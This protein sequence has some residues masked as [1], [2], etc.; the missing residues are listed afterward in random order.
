MRRLWRTASSD[1]CRRA[2]E[3]G[4]ALAEFALIAP[5]L[6]MFLFGIIEF[7]FVLSRSQAVEAAAR[8]GGRLASLS[9][10]DFSTIED[11][12]DTTLTGV[13]LDGPPSVSV[14]P[15]VCDGREGQSV[16][17]TV[18][19]PHRLTIPFVFDRLM[20]LQGRSVFRCEA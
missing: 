13:A 16:T 19:A 9:T 6:M 8:E 2:D 4:A 1:R 10:S 15:A 17:V 3:R 12:V 20:T 18:T 14:T 7:S 11:R 5:L